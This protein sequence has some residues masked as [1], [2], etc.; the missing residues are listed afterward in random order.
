MIG[1]RWIEMQSQ[2]TWNKRISE[3]TKIVINKR[4]CPGE[5]NKTKK[6]AAEW[7]MPTKIR[8]KLKNIHYKE[9]QIKE[10]CRRKDECRQSES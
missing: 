4:R 3:K 10:N 8:T 6:L 2:A 1:L 7:C 9:R 5:E